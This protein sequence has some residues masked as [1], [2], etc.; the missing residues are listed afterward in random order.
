MAQNGDSL[1][2][3]LQTYTKATLK[4]VL[5]EKSMAINAICVCLHGKEIIIFKVY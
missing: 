5:D 2:S 4:K 3:V 1:T